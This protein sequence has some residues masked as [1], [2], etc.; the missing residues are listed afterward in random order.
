LDVLRAQDGFVGADDELAEGWPQLR[1]EH[2]G[3]V[4]RVCLAFV[5]LPR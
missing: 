4:V 1:F 3:R 2:E 5:D